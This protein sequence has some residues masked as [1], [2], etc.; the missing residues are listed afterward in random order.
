MKNFNRKN[1]VLAKFALDEH[2]EQK[3]ALLDNLNSVAGKMAEL[4]MEAK[5]MQEKSRNAQN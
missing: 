2:D 3:P 4:G 1:I 5:E